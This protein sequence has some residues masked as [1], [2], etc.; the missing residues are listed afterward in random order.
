MGHSRVLVAVLFLVGLFSVSPAEADC[1][2]PTIVT[3]PAERTAVANGDSRTL[4]IYGEG[5]RDRCNDTSVGCFQT[6]PAASP[7]GPIILELSKRSPRLLEK[8]SYGKTPKGTRTVGRTFTDDD[9]RF[10]VVLDLTGVKPGRWALIARAAG[11]E[12]RQLVATF[13]LSIGR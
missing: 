9:A 4:T 6:E 2:G 7:A 1:A 3:S 13:D 8:I 12:V 11:P 10:S 5:W